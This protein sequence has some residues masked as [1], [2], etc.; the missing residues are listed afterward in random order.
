[1]L[2]LYLCTDYWISL[3]YLMNYSRFYAGS[4]CG[5][6]PTKNLLVIHVISMR[7]LS[8]LRRKLFVTGVYAP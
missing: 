1:M 3:N 7:I 5:Y 8:E 4:F 6:Y 2:L